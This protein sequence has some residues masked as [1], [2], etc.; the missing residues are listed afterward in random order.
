MENPV[1]R[2]TLSQWIKHPTTILLIIVTSVAY[3]IGFLYIASLNDQ[4][5]YL[6]QRTTSLES[7]LDEYT[8]TILFQEAKEKGL[9]DE[10][11]KK[12]VQID[13]LKGGPTN[14]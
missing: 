10:L 5:K 8:A 11:V 12:E 9:K 13:S 3:G 2:F 1:N 6:K 14:D 7:K 4:I